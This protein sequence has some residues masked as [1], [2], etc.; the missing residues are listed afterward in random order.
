M[1][2]I[3]IRAL[4]L[5]LLVAAG[6]TSTDP[7]RT[8]IGAECDVP[9]TI[10]AKPS[11]DCAQ[12]SIEH[13]QQD[14][15]RFDIA[16][17]E[18]TDQGWFHNRKQMK[19]ALKL[20]DRKGDQRLEIVLFVH[21][22]KHSARSD[23]VDVA[24]F[25]TSVM[26]ALTRSEPGTRTVGIYVGWRGA[27]LDL[28]SAAQSITF[29]DRKSTADHVARGSVRELLSRLRA[30]RNDRTAAPAR[31]V[32]LTL[33][34]HSFGSLILFN[35]IAESLL[36]SMVTAD[37]AAPTSP[38]LAEPIADLVLFVNPAFE[39]SRFEP[40][41]QVAKERLAANVSPLTYSDE[42]RPILVSITSEA[43]LATK[44]AFPAGRTVNSVLQHE[45]WTDQDPDDHGSENYG[46][47][48]EKIANTHTM[49]HM[50][51]YRTHRL[52]LGTAASAPDSAMTSALPPVECN[53]VPNA[54]VS[55]GN[56]FPLW[57]MYAS[58]SLIDGHH[59][60]YKS[61]LWEFVSRLKDEAIAPDQLCR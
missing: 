17:V 33:I 19:E 49:G 11:P 45:A 30:I 7:Y 44:I 5:M 3:G 1:R 40:L 55:D 22:W 2:P 29:Y 36:Y 42:Q 23:D 48:L 50:E 61:N 12:A 38:R 34:G 60:I 31:K 41:F 52:G 16:Y 4:S 27:V 59:D 13:V 10:A 35:A 51:R 18:L 21:G 58:E 56:R 28:P 6:C 25:R 9:G 24:H 47:R 53:R 54:F 46:R 37:Y 8:G 14:G 43:D 15:K 32:G 26:P 57:N 20:I 39:A